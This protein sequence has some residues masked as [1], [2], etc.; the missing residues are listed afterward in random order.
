M[1]AIPNSG[2]KAARAAAADRLAAQLAR[3]VGQPMVQKPDKQHET[4][5]DHSKIQQLEDRTLYALA[6]H[7]GD[8]RITGPTWLTLE[9]ASILRRL[10]Y[11]SAT[12]AP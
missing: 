7:D 2:K 5:R 3:S 6:V 4:T 9:K 11:R 10:D 1:D 12:S 8:T